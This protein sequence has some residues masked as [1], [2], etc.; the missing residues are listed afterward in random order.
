MK[1]LVVLAV[2]LAVASAA[3]LPD[4]P[5]LLKDLPL[6]EAEID[7][8]ITNG[9]KASAGQFPYQAGLS[10]KSS[11]GSSW[12]GG[13]LIG[14]QWVLTAAHCTDGITSVTVY[15]GSTTRT[16]ADHSVTVSSSN[17]KQHTGYKSSTLANDI[18]L[19]KIPAVTY[20]SKISAIKLPAI[21]SS[22]STYAGSTAIA[23]GWGRTTNSKFLFFQNVNL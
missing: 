22:Y 17:F 15:L 19:I 5:V 18:S 20:T 11:A 9:N 4:K 12:C 21:A 7:G 3:V 14:N 23:S 1:F 13:S 8:R 10:L 6:E 16:V 2:T